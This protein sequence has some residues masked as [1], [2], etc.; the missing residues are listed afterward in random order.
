[1]QTEIDELGQEVF[2]F[3]REQSSK[4]GLPLHACINRQLLGLASVAAAQQSPSETALLEQ[5][6]SQI[7]SQEHQLSR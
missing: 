4:R 3:L 1:M 5:Q 7:L 6:L 2:Q